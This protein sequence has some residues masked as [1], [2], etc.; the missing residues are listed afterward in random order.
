MT[1]NS[2]YVFH[3]VFKILS[4]EEGREINVPEALSIDIARQPR[5]YLFC[6]SMYTRK[7]EIPR[8]SQNSAFT[9]RS[10]LC[11]RR[12]KN[13]MKKKTQNRREQPLCGTVLRPPDSLMCSRA[14]A[15]ATRVCS[16]PLPPIFPDRLSLSC[17]FFTSLRFIIIWQ[18]PT[19]RS[20]CGWVVVIVFALQNH[21]IFVPKSCCSEI[22]TNCSSCNKL[23]A[24]TQPRL[25]GYEDSKIS[26]K[27]TRYS[28]HKQFHVELCSALTFENFASVPCSWYGNNYWIRI[29]V[30]REGERERE[31]EGG[32]RLIN[33]FETRGLSVSR[34]KAHEAVNINVMYSLR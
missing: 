2:P 21:R 8:V 20:I 16:A 24:R 27:W 28:V 29:Q 13:N 11:L 5:V 10:L 25:K 33:H 12:V 15:H 6:F 32:W 3:G 26:I 17:T 9:W 31:W 1:W 14:C 34:F 30:E 23:L 18:P 19:C 4:V 7:L 22:S